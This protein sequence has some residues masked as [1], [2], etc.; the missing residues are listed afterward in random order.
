[1]GGYESSAL[2]KGK[3]MSLFLWCESA[4]ST[5]D[6]SKALSDKDISEF[7]LQ[8]S[9]LVAI[10]TRQQFAGRGRGGSEWVQPGALNSPQITASELTL[11]SCERFGEI[12]SD[13]P[14]TTFRVASESLKIPSSWVPLMVGCAIIDALQDLMS[15][16]TALVP[17]PLE[18]PYQQPFLLK[19]PND[20]LV[21]LAEFRKVSGVLCESSFQGQKMGA[22]HIGVGLNLMAHPNVGMSS[23]VFESF[24]WK[25]ASSK[26]KGRKDKFLKLA[27]DKSIGKILSQRFFLTLIKELEEYLFVDRSRG[28]LRGLALERSMPRGMHLVVNKG[29]RQGAFAGLD[30]N[31]GL[32]LADQSLAVQA[33]DVVL[34]PP[35]VSQKERLKKFL[36]SRKQNSELKG[37]ELIGSE[38][39]R[40]ELKR[41]E[42]KGSELKG[43][44]LLLVLEI[45]NTRIHAQS[46]AATL[47]SVRDSQRNR[48]QAGASFDLP[49]S[50]LEE[51]SDDGTAFRGFKPLFSGLISQKQKSVR[52]VYTSVAP[53]KKTH[54]FL[55][56][57][58]KFFVRLFPEGKWHTQ[59]LDAKVLLAGTP[60]VE[61]Y[62][63]STLGA[64][65]ALRL[66][67]CWKEASK[68]GSA[69]A[70]L[71]LGTATT[72]ECV[73]PDGKI[74]ES[75][76]CA[77]I[78]SSLHTLH[79]GTARLP[80]LNNLAALIPAVASQMRPCTTEQ[81]LANGVLLPISNSRF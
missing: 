31:G 49:W 43:S 67:H 60:L 37:S 51:E 41:S 7:G 78:E 29:E 17:F 80:L 75:W 38:L 42:L 2:P 53:P 5:Q 39:K 45:G 74:L 14:P 64:D 59:I 79:G 30:L 56:R 25:A 1:M 18:L 61:Q 57:L 12:F 16:A 66:L 24:F 54:D 52:V 15:F 63:L 21:K 65:R 46:N 9:P 34:V 33:G 13:F 4:S 77:G 69:M 6:V 44:E 70:C 48:V 35:P 26:E 27:N 10:C 58:E 50:I 11:S 71:S 62:Q 81:S 68:T 72:L 28:Q 73:N 76:I 8:D 55:V 32:L 47:D 22:L 19:W 20:V 40:S 3:H 23:S 36:N